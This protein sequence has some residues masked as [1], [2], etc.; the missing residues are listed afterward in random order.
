MRASGATS[1]LRLMTEPET[2][3][4]G[5]RDIAEL[6]REVPVGVLRYPMRALPDGLLTTAIG[7]E[8]RAR[9]WRE[10]CA[11]AR[12]AACADVRTPCAQAGRGSCRADI[13]YP[14][15]PG[16]GAPSHRMATLFVHWRPRARALWLSALGEVARD[17]LRWAGAR[18]AAAFEL[19]N[20]EWL[21]V[22]R[23]SD[24]ELA[25]HRRWRIEITSPW[26]IGKATRA[27][28][29]RERDRAPSRDDV[30]R[31]LRKSIVARAH[32]LT[33]LALRGPHAQRIGAHLAHY[34]G[35]ALLGCALA[36]LE[37]HI[38]TLRLP[39]Q[40]LGSNK[41]YEALAWTGTMVVDVAPSA[42]A[43]LTLLGLCGGGDNPDK[44]FGSVEITPMEGG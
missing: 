6:W 23:F 3:V 31:E 16:G 22:D 35:E 27:K 21:P 11:A 37:V 25:G 17:E 42:L 44:G 12:G 36:T 2:R 1:L 15:Y 34:A 14:A 9:A 20:P 39:A 29:Q 30:D 4:R 24:L 41:E 10:R 38:K 7:D 18:L 26:M 19:P 8:L 40:R 5:A 33:A 43:W 13:L 28:R 32:K